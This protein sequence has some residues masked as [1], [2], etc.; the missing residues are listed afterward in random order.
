MATRKH[1]YIYRRR[2]IVKTYIVLGIS[3]F[4]IL[5][6]TGKAR[7]DERSYVWTYEYSTLA[8]GST[9]LEFYQTATTS[10]KNVSSGSDWTQQ[11]ELEYGI[12]D[13]LDAAIYEIY[14]QSNTGGF[15]YAGYNVRLRYRIAEKNALPVD[16]LLY[17]EHQQRTS[18]DSAFEGKVV[19]A[20]EFGRSHIAYNQIYERSYDTGKGEH[21]YALGMSYETAPMIRLGVESKGS[22]SEDEYAAG[23]TIAWTGGRIWANLG[24][25]FALNNKTND[26]EIRFLLG[27]PF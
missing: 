6:M 19:L 11:I 4:V 25:L 3:L 15:S 13:H 1:T 17:F 20:K 21:E 27:V 26:R 18:G 16:T 14:E 22:Y 12:T 9:E 8:K 24:A 2:F 5:V 23:P 7:A 10:N